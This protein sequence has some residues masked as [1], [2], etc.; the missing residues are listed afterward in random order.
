M[1]TG[2][3]YGTVRV[4]NLEKGEQEGTSMKHDREICGLAVTWDGA[5]IIS[6]YWKGSIKVWDV[7]S[8]KLLR[9]WTHPEG[10]PTGIAISPDDRLIAVGDQVV[11][12]YSMEGT[13]VNRLIM[14]GNT[15]CSM[16]FSPNRKKLACGSDNDTEGSKITHDE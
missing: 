3:V 6:S 16:S 5:R 8:H 7:E 1:V 2:S 9:E 13:Q 14:V 12:I 11:A 10:C 15:A 4:W